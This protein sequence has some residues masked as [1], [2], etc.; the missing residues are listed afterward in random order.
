MFDGLIQEL[1]EQKLEVL[2]YAADLA[3]VGIGIAELKK[4][5]DTIER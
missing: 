4:A 5:V 1:K 3:I 2:A